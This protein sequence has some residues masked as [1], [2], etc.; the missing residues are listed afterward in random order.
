MAFQVML[1]AIA[2]GGALGISDQ[3]LCL[4]LIGLAAQFKWIALLPEVSW[5]GSWVFIAIV[6]VLWVLTALPAYG[7][8]LDPVFLRFINTTVGLFSGV[9]VPAS[10][11]LLALATVQMVSPDT[12]AAWRGGAF[13]L[14]LANGGSDMDLVIVGTG[15]ATLASV[16]TFLKFLL[17]P[18]LSTVTG[19]VGTTASG[20]VYKTAENVLSVVVMGLI[21]LFSAHPWLLILLASIIIVGLFAGLTFAVYKLW[22]IS[23]G[24]G[25]V[26]RLFETDPRAGMAVIVEPFIWGAGWLLVKQ[27]QHGPYRLALWGVCVL[28]IWLAVPLALFFVPP[29]AAIAPFVLSIGGIYLVGG[30]SAKKLLQHV[31]PAQATGAVVPPLPG[32]MPQVA[33]PGGPGVYPTQIGM[34]AVAASPAAA[35]PAAVSPAGWA[36]PPQPAVGYAPTKMVGSGLWGQ[37]VAIGGPQQGQV[38]PLNKVSVLIGRAPHCDI[39]I[40]DPGVSGQHARLELCDQQVFIQDLNSSNGTV[41]NRQRLGPQPAGLYG[42]EIVILNNTVIRFERIGAR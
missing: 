2:S 10:G 12:A 22:Q 37:L 14:S 8:F 36:A 41:V 9:L 26:L 7:S 27:W 38:F 5:M 13:Y 20:A 31:I 21:W 35:A 15:G 28:V 18:M 24:I 19:L 17:K 3:Y 1:S 6:G 32:I 11:A 39:V 30:W 34:S 16:V 42:G 4:L 33:V 25:R 29:L 23:Q 40:V